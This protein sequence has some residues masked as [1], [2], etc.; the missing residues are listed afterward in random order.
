ME[1]Q[2]LDHGGG[3]LHHLMND[4][5]VALWIIVVALLIAA[6]F[7]LLDK[8]KEHAPTPNKRLEARRAKQWKGD[9][10]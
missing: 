5:N 7:L 3:E 10:V 6:V 1:L 9:D 2:Y 8:M 4:P